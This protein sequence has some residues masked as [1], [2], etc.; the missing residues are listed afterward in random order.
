MKLVTRHIF[1][2]IMG[3]LILAQ[4]FSKTLICFN[5]VLNKDYIAEVLCI[6]KD[7][8]E[9]A[10]EG[11]CHLKEQLDKETEKEETP[12]TRLTE[13][14]ELTYFSNVFFLRFTHSFNLD[15]VEHNTLYTLG[16]NKAH[17]SSTY[18]PPNC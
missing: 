1:I 13:K 7:V 2:L 4:T 6:N 9:L 17:L 18:H 10:C 5:Y 11:K 16:D 8:P 15:I 14:H 3:G 12:S